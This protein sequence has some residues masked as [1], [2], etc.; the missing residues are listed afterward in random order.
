[1]KRIITW[2]V[3]FGILLGA[4]L[5]IMSF[6][7]YLTGGNPVGAFEFAYLLPLYLLVMAGGLFYF[8]NYKN[9]G[10]LI[11]GHSLLMALL[12]NLTGA[13]FYAGYIYLLFSSSPETLEMWRD[14]MVEVWLR[15]AEGMSEPDI[16]GGTRAVRQTRPAKI[17]TDKLMKVSSMGLL[18]TFVVGVAFRR[19][20]VKRNQKKQA[21]TDTKQHRS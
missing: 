6:I 16:E 1:M 9:R 10:E 20:L 17:A 11:T 19:R 15:T 3:L 5:S 12:I 8:R 2:G 21:A 4:L 7:V 14:Q 18:F 13:A